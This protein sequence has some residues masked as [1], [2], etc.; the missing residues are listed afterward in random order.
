MWCQSVGQ[1]CISEAVFEQCV[2]MFM[3]CP[4]KLG[5]LLFSCAWCCWPLIYTKHYSQTNG[6][7]NTQK[8]ISFHNLGMTSCSYFYLFIL[9]KTAWCSAAA[10]RANGLWGVIRKRI[11]NKTGNVILMQHILILC[12]G[13]SSGHQ[14]QKGC[15]STNVTKRSGEAIRGAEDFCCKDETN[16]LALSTYE[17]RGFLAWGKITQGM[18]FQYLSW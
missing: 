13:C 18:T 3:G 15:N 14:W 9:L 2:Q 17:K 12:T 11:K 7:T 6:L 5:V 16:R 10:K 4:M 1:L 8:I